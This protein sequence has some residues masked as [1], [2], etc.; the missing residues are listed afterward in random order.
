MPRKE[1]FPRYYG[2]EMLTSI[3][4]S[5][6]FEN[7]F[8]FL[9]PVS[10]SNMIVS[11]K[12]FRKGFQLR[13]YDG[14][15]RE[16]IKKRKLYDRYR[17]CPEFQHNHLMMTLRLTCKNECFSCLGTTKVKN[18]SSY[19]IRVCHECQITKPIYTQITRSTAMKEYCLKGKEVDELAH[20]VVKNPVFSSAAPMR[21]YILNDVLEISKNRDVEAIKQKKQM[22]LEK[23][24]K[25][26]AD[27][28]EIRK[29]QLI[30]ALHNIGL[31]LRSDSELCEQYLDGKIQNMSL[32][33][34]VREMAVMKYLYEYTDYENR[35]EEKV[36]ELSDS[37]GYYYSGIWR[38]A[39]DIVKIRYAIPHHWP[40]LV[41][42]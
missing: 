33:Q 1:K 42:K 9:D 26:V 30:D 17:E 13:E 38:Q 19:N 14:C 11:C 2:K 20:I 35:L 28:K 25:T 39:S 36:D 6:C 3:P 40:W 34:L 23:R 32:A 37:A 10:V 27:K 8:V 15:W 29:Q 22:S 12:E 7:L 24:R 16:F 21:L 41:V 4:L 18:H 5:L 31:E